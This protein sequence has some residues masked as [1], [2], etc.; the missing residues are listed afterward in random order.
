MQA[1]MRRSNNMKLNIKI[2]ERAEL[3]ILTIK[4]LVGCLKIAC[5]LLI[6]IAAIFAIFVSVKNFSSSYFPGYQA[7]VYSYVGIFA[8]FISLLILC[9]FKR[10][11]I[12]A[13]SEKM[14]QLRED[15]EKSIDEKIHDTLEKFQSKSGW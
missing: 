10:E 15:S 12:Q 1:K 9:I 8:V 6:F 2:S 11:S 4:R 7:F 3:H 14:I 5:Q 13:F